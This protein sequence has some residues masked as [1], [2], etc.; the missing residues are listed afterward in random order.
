[1]WL[2]FFAVSELGA[3]CRCKADCGVA[4]VCAVSSE[5]GVRKG[6][7]VTQ[8]VL[9]SFVEGSF[10]CF[11]TFP[12]MRMWD[13]SGFD[14][15]WLDLFLKHNPVN[16]PKSTSANYHGGF[17]GH[18]WRYDY[19][20]TVSI[21]EAMPNR[22][23]GLFEPQKHFFQEFFGSDCMCKKLLFR[24]VCWWEQVP[25]PQILC[26]SLYSEEF[27]REEECGYPKLQS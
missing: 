11:W 14:K 13:F 25:G 26:I 20:K 3:N 24:Q 1:V 18:C 7:H 2:E 9:K 6:A 21:L 10:P 4:S 19:D 23:R 27:A 8:H 12:K 17:P 22:R 16:G 5:A 15:C